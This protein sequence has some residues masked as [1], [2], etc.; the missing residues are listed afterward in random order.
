MYLYII[1]EPI[2]SHSLRENNNP[3][4]ENDPSELFMHLSMSSPKVGGGGIRHRVGILT[5][6]KKN[7][8]NPHPWAEN[9]GKKYGLLPFCSL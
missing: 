2:F 3:D 7:Y 9:N 1:R 5:L 8:Q 4:I 6:A